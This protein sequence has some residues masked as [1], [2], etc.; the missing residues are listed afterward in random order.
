MAR[1]RR[2]WASAGL[3]ATLA[4]SVAATASPVAGAPARL[5]IDLEYQTD[6]GLAECPSEVAFRTMISEQIGYDPFRADSQQRVV[7][8]ALA[9]EHGIRGFVEWYDAAGNPRGQRELDSE[10]ADCPAFARAMSFAIA[11]QIQLLAQ[12]AEAAAEPP[13]A[14]DE[15]A[16][17]APPAEAPG[18]ERDRRRASPGR[19][20]E[21]DAPWQLL[22]GAGPGLAFGLAP[23]TAV[24]GRV[25]AALRHGWLAAELGAEASL[26]A[27]YATAP[28][29]GFEQRVALG[30]L[31]GC[32]LWEALSGCVVSKLGV[33][34][35]HG[36]GVDAPRSPSGVAAQIG[37]RLGLGQVFSD[38]FLAG[39]RLE[40]LATLVSWEVTLNQ[41]EVWETPAV[42]LSAGA[43]LG[44]LFQ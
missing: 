32:A 26:P 19:S 4:L 13:Q 43:E 3:P 35:V 41:R 7:A 6:P 33:I 9:T 14:P 38:R 44:A 20:T 15:A 2:L 21:A 16:A 29:E 1:L 30:S 18:R 42:S 28:G 37:P 12:E 17:P 11:V 34:E 5:F 10:Q 31:A 8:R 27:R 25:F 23:R 24:E 22:V 36:F 40:L 39:V